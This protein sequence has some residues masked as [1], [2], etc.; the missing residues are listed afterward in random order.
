MVKLSF[1]FNHSMPSG[2]S[3]CPQDTNISN[4]IHS[5][6]WDRKQHLTSSLF[7]RDMHI[8]TAEE[9]ASCFSYWFRVHSEFC[10][11]V[12]NCFVRQY[13]TRYWQ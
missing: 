10:K 9:R 5:R 4:R 6:H 12:Q 8:L 7:L 11:T 3:I 1:Q 13:P 2:K